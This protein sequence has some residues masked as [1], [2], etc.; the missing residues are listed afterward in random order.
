MNTPKQKTK[1]G[2][3][4]TTSTHPSTIRARPATF[5][6]P[7][8]PYAILAALLVFLL[9]NTGAHAIPTPQGV[10]GTVY[11]LDGITPVP[12]YV[13][14][15]IHNKETGQTIHT[16][17][18][19]GRPGRYSAALNWPK[20]TTVIVTAQNPEHE[21]NATV[22]LEG[23][24]H[25]VDLYLNMTLSP[26]PPIITSTPPTEVMQDQ[27]YTYRPH[28]FD[29]NGDTLTHALGTRPEGMHID[30][31]TGLITWT[32]NAT[33]VGT[34]NV[35]Y[36]VSDGN[37]TT[38]QQYN[39]TVQNV[40]DPP[41]LIIPTRAV[42]KARGN[43]LAYQLEAKDL[44]NDPV[45]FTLKQAPPGFSVTPTGLL[46]YN[47]QQPPPRGSSLIL[48]LNDGQ[49][50]TTYTLQIDGFTF[51][52]P[53]PSNDNA[54][55]SGSSSALFSK[56]L[57]SD[58]TQNAS[59]QP[60]ASA[61]EEDKENTEQNT[62][63]AAL[64]YQPG[65]G[66][67]TSIT[68]AA[69][70]PLQTI[71]VRAFERRPRSTPPL[72]EAVISYFR[73]VP[74]G[75]VSKI[76]EVTFTIHLTTQDLQRA[77][78]TDEREGDLQLYQ[79][80][81]NQWK[82]INTKT[83]RTDDGIILSAT[84]DKLALFALTTGSPPAPRPPS[85]VAIPQATTIIGTLTPTTNET[86]NEPVPVFITDTQT[87]KRYRF[88]TGTT[89]TPASF[90]AVLHDVAG[91]E[92]VLYAK[93]KNLEGEKRIQAT[94]GTIQITLPLKPSKQTILTGAVTAA[95]TVLAPLTNSNLAMLFFLLAAGALLAGAAFMH[96]TKARI[97]KGKNEK[98]TLPPTIRE[99]EKE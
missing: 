8:P 3:N 94:P 95:S 27:R 48:E 10:D 37:Q 80:E 63:V 24:L 34:H 4:K 42:L 60:N 47:R 36:H 6:L 55:G 74:Q 31:E 85:I 99:W 64:T 30:N 62:R 86:I 5:P 87:G 41:E 35:V 14:L 84:S 17:P 66:L 33:Q 56:E 40:N 72:N 69:E 18:G 16:N 32:P 38:T 91:H 73:F 81:D 71:R 70:Q 9:I 89:P 83:R 90:A 51:Q 45:R 21:A 49:A 65:D 93:T 61:N 78:A 75:T 2:A 98:E 79:L 44:D 50:T 57:Y 92:L 13:T 96:L 25:G 43:I 28:V 22:Q 23:I 19:R 11:E 77:G 7:T 26:Y 97:K 46:T 88:D 52:F 39:L 1:K 76:S 59:N 82:R 15:T 29:W 67:I 54:G 68:I 53:S 12:P 58:A 20:G